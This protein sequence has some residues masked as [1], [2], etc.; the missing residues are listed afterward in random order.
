MSLV[1]SRDRNHLPLFLLLPSNLLPRS[2][3]NSLAPMASTESS[4]ANYSVFRECLSSAI[5]EKS[6][7]HR[8]TK[9]KRKA[10]KPGP[11]RNGKVKKDEPA[12]PESSALRGNPEELADFIDVQITPRIS[13]DFLNTRLP[14]CPPC[15]VSGYTIPGQW[16]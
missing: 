4:D 2:I 5:V 14:T 6:D 8:P 16:Q 11:R 1:F 3:S 13:I 10:H 12:E 9:T 15:S 7:T